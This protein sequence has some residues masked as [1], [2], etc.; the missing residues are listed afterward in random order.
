[1]RHVAD[2]VDEDEQPDEG[3]H[4][5]H[6]RGERVQHPAE[7]ERR[8]TQ[9]EPGEVEDL[10]KGFLV[11]KGRNECRAREDKRKNHR[12]DGERRRERALALLRQ[13]AQPCR[14]QRQR[15]D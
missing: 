12:A 5:L 13:R 10:A 1:M 11:T 2:A 4:Q 3:H 14:Q 15:R 7:L 8:L 6:D 9:L